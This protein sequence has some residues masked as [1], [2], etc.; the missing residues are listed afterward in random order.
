LGND[1]YNAALIIV[2]SV[3]QFMSHPANFSSRLWLFR[4]EELAIVCGYNLEELRML[5]SFKISPVCE[6]QF[7]HASLQLSIRA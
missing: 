7:M 5:A 4:F 2:I 6:Y 3:F 1:A